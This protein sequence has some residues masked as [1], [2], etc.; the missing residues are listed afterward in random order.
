MGEEAE[1]GLVYAASE[2]ESEGLPGGTLTARSR[3][4]ARLA[5][6]AS[7]SG[8]GRRAPAQS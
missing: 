2:S 4:R 3:M 1:G 8:C 6:A 5:D 7:F